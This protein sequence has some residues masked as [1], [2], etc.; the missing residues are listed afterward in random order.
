[1]E[2]S[3]KS[4]PVQLAYNAFSAASAGAGLFEL[5]VRFLANKEPKTQRLSFASSFGIVVAQS[6]THFKDAGYLKPIE[7]QFLQTTKKL[8][9]K[10][11]HAEFKE[12]IKILVDC[13]GPFKG[14]SVKHGKF[15][16]DPTKMIQELE[17][18]I[19]GGG[20]GVGSQPFKKI[21]HFGY[22]LEANQIGALARATAFFA[23]AIQI[24]DRV[25][26]DHARVKSGRS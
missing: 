17:N 11:L 7:V 25:A 5:R 10:L 19:G 22:F 23:K 16:G 8:R 9:D 18:I 1:M 21:G 6:I 3:K 26:E 2:N 12:L 15:S 13:S 20:V 14:A 24:I 4:D